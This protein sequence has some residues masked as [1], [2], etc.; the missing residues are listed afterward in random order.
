[1]Y[2]YYI[3]D[4]SHG[5]RVKE[6]YW[7]NDEFERVAGDAFVLFYA[8]GVSKYCLC[9]RAKTKKSHSTC[10]SWKYRTYFK[11]VSTFQ[12]SFIQQSQRR[13]LSVTSLRHIILKTKS[14]RPRVSLQRWL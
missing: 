14:K 12:M 4:T 11:C 5:L 6:D 1:M 9:A 7:K 3:A 8:P 13:G 10:R 2:W